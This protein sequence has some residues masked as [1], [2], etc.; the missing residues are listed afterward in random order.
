MNAIIPLTVLIEKYGY[1]IIIIPY[2]SEM[3]NNLNKPNFGSKDSLNASLKSI[4]LLSALIVVLNVVIARRFRSPTMKPIFQTWMSTS[5]S[6]TKK[7]LQRR[8]IIHRQNN[9][10]RGNFVSKGS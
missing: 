2:L 9:I 10:P 5:K 6:S 4:S 3:I 8:I 1:V 7:K